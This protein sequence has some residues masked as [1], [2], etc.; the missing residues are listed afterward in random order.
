MTIRAIAVFLVLVLCC[1]G[2]VRAAGGNPV[3]VVDLMP[4]FFDAWDRGLGKPLD[5]RVRLFESEVIYPNRGAYDNSQFKL[6][7]AHLAWYLNEVEP[8]IP[9]M[10]R[11]SG[12][13]ATELPVGERAFV[14]AFPDLRPVTVYFLPSLMHFDGQT[15]NGTLFFRLDGLA[16]FDGPNANLSVIVTHELF[17]IYHYQ[18]NPGVFGESG[19]THAPVHAQLWSEGL[20]TYV[21]QR[22]NPTATRAQVLESEELAAL[23]QAK[24]RELA[25]AIEPKL[26]SAQDA[27]ATPFFD[28]GV[29]PAGLP[30][31]GG[32]L[33][34]LL[35][36]EQLGATHTLRELA[37][38]KGPELRAAIASGARRLCAAGSAPR[39]S[40]SL[41]ERTGMLTPD[42]EIELKQIAAQLTASMLDNHNG[43]WDDKD[44]ARAFRTIYEAVK[45]AT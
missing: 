2:G 24:T 6:D 29:K 38:L 7:D 20:A 13:I 28:L 10:R 42:Q 26:D 11:M 18:V 17:H 33:V 4:A 22:L 35:V 34:G 1:R 23:P 15:R 14:A 25:C 21:S 40:A 19:S 41:H 39:S 44:T 27:D 36:A 5:D 45:N 37:L 8:W 12:T 30:P 43:D 9:Q 16:A 31:R 3:R 32:Y